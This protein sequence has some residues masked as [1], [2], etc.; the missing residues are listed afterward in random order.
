MILQETCRVVSHRLRGFDSAEV[1]PKGVVNALNAGVKGIE[2]D[3]RITA[4]GQI[5]INHDACIYKGGK[6]ICSQTLISS[7]AEA[8]TIRGSRLMLLEDLLEQVAVYKE[9]GPILYIDI[10]ENG[11]EDIILAEIQK[12]QLLN[13]VVIVSWLPEVLFRLNDL[14]GGTLPLCFSHHAVS[15]KFTSVTMKYRA[16]WGSRFSPRLRVLQDRYNTGIPPRDRK[17]YGEDTEHIVTNGV[18]GDLA[19]VI[20]NSK[21]AVC[22]Y[23]RQMTENIRDYYRN[24]G[25]RT[26]VYSID[27]PGK[28]NAFLQ[29]FDTTIVLTN[30]HQLCSL[31][32]VE[33]S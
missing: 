15:N 31:K 25:I 20:S 12:H 29:K 11:Y 23:W 22:I 4:D 2:F 6:P 17:T 24:L 19:E 14:S 1:S 8:V 27:K 5:V 10:K 32:A 21:G 26:V 30:N 28:L 3:T 33:T 16:I 13:R 7:Q 9:A 18:K